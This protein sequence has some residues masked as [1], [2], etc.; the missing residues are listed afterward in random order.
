MATVESSLCPANI[1]EAP[2]DLCDIC[3]GD[4][5]LCELCY[6]PCPYASNDWDSRCKAPECVNAGQCTL[7]N[8]YVLAVSI[9][10]KDDDDEVE[11][12]APK[13]CESCTNCSICNIVL[14]K[15]D[16]EATNNFTEGCFANGDG[17]AQL[18]MGECGTTLTVG[19]GTRDDV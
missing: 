4:F 14:Y 1:H 17:C 10:K 11:Y 8:E 3:V 18:C 2:P 15:A 12:E 7:C 16:G 6:K 13:V 5:S 19:A 9:E